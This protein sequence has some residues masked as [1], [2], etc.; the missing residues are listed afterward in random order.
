MIHREFQHLF[1]TDHSWPGIVPP[2]V[3]SRVPVAFR[4]GRPVLHWG[5][6]RVIMGNY[7]SLRQRMHEKS[8][9]QII[10]TCRRRSSWGHVSDA[11]GKTKEHIKQLLNKQWNQILLESIFDPIKE[12]NFNKKDI[13]RNVPL[14]TSFLRKLNSRKSGSFH[15][16][17]LW[18]VLWAL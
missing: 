11:L 13:I 7:G 5:H 4:D 12:F 1:K 14:W 2:R 9:L 3:N 10:C 8:G 6:T 15:L 18:F 17:K 16:W